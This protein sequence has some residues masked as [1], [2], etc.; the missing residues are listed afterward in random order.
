MFRGGDRFINLMFYEK[1]E[2]CISDFFYRFWISDVK[3]IVLT[4]TNLKIKYNINCNKKIKSNII[5][6]FHVQ[7]YKMGLQFFPKFVIENFLY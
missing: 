4:V 3:H 1:F 6:I 5:C 7:H 2:I